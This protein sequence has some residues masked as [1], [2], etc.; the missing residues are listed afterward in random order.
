[1]KDLIAAGADVNTPDLA[2]NTPLHVAVYSGLLPII[3]LLIV[4][5]RANPAKSNRWTR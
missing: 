5:G 1:M 4:K 2:G 3:E